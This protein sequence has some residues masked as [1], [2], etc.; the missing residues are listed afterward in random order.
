MKKNSNS[1]LMFLTLVA[2][3]GGL[4]FGY[5]TA[6]I[7]GTVKY[8]EINFVDPLGL[9]ETAASSL[10]G[11]AVSSALIG[12]VIGG[13]I[14]GF[15][16]TRLGRKRSLMIAAVLFVLSAI[17]S[18]YPEMGFPAGQP[19]EF[20]VCFV[21]YRIIGGVGV[22]LASMLS[23]MYIAEMAPAEKR[24]GL[25]SWNQFAIIF[26]MLVVYFVNYT[27]ALS[28]D[29]EWLTHT[30]WRLMFL[31]E[32]VPAM[33]LLILIF[34]VPESPRWLV[35]KGR[36]EK[37]ETILKRGRPASGYPIGSRE[38]PGVITRGSQSKTVQLWCGCDCDRNP[39]VRF[40]AVCGDQCCTLLCARNFPQYGYGYQCSSDADHYRGC[41]Q[42]FVHDTGDLHRGPFRTS[43]AGDYRQFGYDGQH[44]Y[45]GIHVLYG[46]YGITFLTCHVGLHGLFCRFVGT[47]LLGVVG[48]DLS[49]QDTGAGNGLGCCGS[50][51]C[52]LSGVVD[53]PDDG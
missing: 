36:I 47:G 46:A 10:L 29:E 15:M 8:L 51:V 24:G 20:I 45:A 28:G 22:G 16:A 26:G 37:A 3:L 52:K 11:F 35:M 41:D 12:C 34:C 9:D 43:P 18:A 42:P 4:L 27:I 2:T 1:Y 21:V 30:G 40:S 49:E 31:S 19:H 6:V 44:D 50:M 23:P 13:M 38:Y 17:G 33:L 39:V 25:V 53:F 32:V 5:D 14:G 7:S 48:G